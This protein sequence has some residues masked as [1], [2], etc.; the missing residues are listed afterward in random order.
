MISVLGLTG[1]VGCVTGGLGAEGHRQTVPQPGLMHFSVLVLSW[2]LLPITWVKKKFISFI[3]LSLSYSNCV[4]VH[5]MGD[6][7]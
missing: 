3:Y 1:V 6:I 5:N 7:I 4:C 2:L